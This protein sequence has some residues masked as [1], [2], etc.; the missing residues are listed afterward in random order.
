[1]DLTGKRVF[2]S[3][4]MTGQEHNNVSLFATAYAIVKKERGASFVYSPAQAWLNERNEICEEKTHDMYMLDCIHELTRRDYTGRPYYDL[5][6]S[7]PDWHRS[8]GAAHERDVAEHCG[9]PC[10]DLQDLIVDG[11]L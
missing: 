5:L 3:G 8:D 2:L 4:P 9:I 10:I 11:A 7:L 6:V 1:M